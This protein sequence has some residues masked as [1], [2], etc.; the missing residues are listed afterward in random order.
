MRAQSPRPAAHARVLAVAGVHRTAMPLKWF[1][2]NFELLVPDR[3]ELPIP[4]LSGLPAPFQFKGSAQIVN[5]LFDHRHNF[6]G[7]AI[8]QNSSIPV[9]GSIADAHARSYFGNVN[10]PEVTKNLTGLFQGLRAIVVPL[11]MVIVGQKI[12]EAR[13][14][15]ARDGSQQVIS[16]LSDLMS[17][18]PEPH[19]K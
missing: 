2:W 15:F 4:R 10:I 5:P 16:V 6:S 8:D 13:P 17:G 3:D 11:V 7:I 12:G 1:V 18:L 14:I 9:T 19:Q